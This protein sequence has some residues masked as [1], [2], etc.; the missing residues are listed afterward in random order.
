[1]V[2]RQC[3]E[4]GEIFHPINPED[5]F[6]NWCETVENAEVFAMC[7]TCGD[8]MDEKEL[9]ENGNCPDCQQTIDKTEAEWHKE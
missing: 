7:E 3:R 4:C 2:K 8:I 1:M 9:D 6:C 5:F